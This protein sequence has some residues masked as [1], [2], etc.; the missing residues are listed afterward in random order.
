MGFNHH[1]CTN[2]TT[3][4]TKTHN[5]L[6]FTLMMMHCLLLYE[7]CTN[8]SMEI[9]CCKDSTHVIVRLSSTHDYERHRRPTFYHLRQ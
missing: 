9:F 7:Y 2:S 5:Q 4:T 8:V 6:M 3:T 1:T